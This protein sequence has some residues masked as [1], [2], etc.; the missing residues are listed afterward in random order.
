[1]TLGDLYLDV[2]LGSG[3]LGALLDLIGVTGLEINAAGTDETLGLEAGVS[4]DFNDGLQIAGDSTSEGLSIGL[5]LGLGDN[6]DF[7]VTLGGINAVINGESSIA[8]DDSLVFVD[9][10]NEPYVNLDLALGLDVDLHANNMSLGGDLGTIS[11]PTGVDL[12]LALELDAKLDLRSLLSSFTGA[13]VSGDNETELA[14]RLLNKADD[15]DEVLLGAYY[16]DGILYVD[17]SALI[18]ARVSTELDIMALLESLLASSGTEG[19]AVTTANGDYSV[20]AFE[21]LMTVTSKGFVI[22]VAQGLTQVI[23]DLIGIDLGEI[24]AALSL[25]W[26]NITGDAD[27]NGNLLDVTVGVGTLADVRVTLAPFGIGLGKVAFDEAASV[28]PAD[29]TTETY[30]SIGSLFNENNEFSADG[31][32]LDSVYAELGGSVK[33]SAS[34]DGETEWSIGEWIGNFTGGIEGITANLQSLIERL[35]FSFVIDKTVSQ[36]IDFN[37]RALLRF[38]ESLNDKDLVKYILS[39]SDI[40]LEISTPDMAEGE[41]LLALYIIAGEDGRSTLYISSA[42]G[43]IIGGKIAV[44]GID[45]GSLIASTETPSAPEGGEEGGAVTSTEGDATTETPEEETDILGTIFGLINRI[46]VT[47]DEARVN[48]GANLLVTL[49]NLLL[50]GYELD[51]ENFLQLDP[52]GSFVSVFYGMGEEGRDIGIELSIAPDPMTIGITLGDLG[53][54]VNDASASVIDEAELAEYKSIYDDDVAVSLDTTLSLELTLLNTEE[55]ENGELPIGDILS[56]L[57]SAIM[58][59]LGVAIRD[60]LTLAV[61]VRLGAN[62]YF[63]DPE[64]TEIMLELRDGGS[65]DGALI[66][67]VYVRGDVLYVDLGMISEGNRFKIENTALVSTVLDA[68]NGALA[69]EADASETSEAVTA[70]D[71]TET[72]EPEKTPLDIILEISEGHLALNVTEAVLLGIIGAVAGT[73]ADIDGIFDALDLGAE[74]S[75]AVDFDRPAVSVEVFTKYANIAIAIEEPY[76]S[77]SVNVDVNDTITAV[78]SDNS[79]Q[80]YQRSSI[81]RFGLDL[82]VRYSADAT[83]TLANEDELDAYPLADRFTKLPDGTFV[84]D[85]EGKYIR[86]GVDLSDIIDTVFGLDAVSDAI[87]GG[88]MDATLRAIVDMLVASLGAELYI[89]DPIGDD[90]AI[91]IFGTLDLETLGLSGILSDFALPTFDVLEILNALQVGLQIVFNPEDENDTA[92][93][94]VYLANGYVYLDLSG[95]GGPKISADLFGILKEMEVAP[96]FEKEQTPE[97][98]G[99]AV[100]EQ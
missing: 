97:G 23:T 99:E 95:L 33:L 61:D 2:V 89:D 41:Y 93:I 5:T 28:I 90:L 43:G 20:G 54:S 47:N 31:L 39:N 92:A 55:L 32:D 82:T 19:D 12:D 16:A 44:P 79:F 76:V 36:E 37:L 49:L 14:L 83:Y 30:P 60:D 45:L 46:Y 65:A 59:D 4:I 9:F 35:V 38:P 53:V 100:T 50:P 18:G 63:N 88:E 11:F 84:Q 51:E 21:F 48:F 3:L 56:A 96:F 81:A 73:D 34:A 10:L 91:S 29:V 1:M 15:A 6:F 87:G 8:V 62:I 25:D 70:T 77:N 74:V 86:R 40:A 94:G 22:E 68:V 69:T 66:L 26:S 42:D 57:T 80:S 17:A 7:G 24:D 72:V 67:G 52:E 27:E 13:T 78:A 58:L 75:V 71:G 64:K 85:N 98:S